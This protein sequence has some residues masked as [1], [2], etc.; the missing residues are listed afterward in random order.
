MLSN[1]LNYQAIFGVVFSR[2]LSSIGTPEKT[3]KQYSADI[4][5]FLIWYE[6]NLPRQP[7]T[8]FDPAEWLRSVTNSTIQSYIGSLRKKNTPASTINRSLAAFRIFFQ[9]AIAYE[10]IREN[11][12]TGIQNV[13]ETS[14][15]RVIDG[16]LTYLNA[17]H[18]SQKT[19]TNYVMDTRHFL[20]W[21]T[22]MRSHDG[23][24]SP[25]ESPFEGISRLTLEHYKETQ[26]GDRVPVAT[27]NR[28]LSALRLFFQYAYEEKLLDT[29]PA[30][31]LQNLL[32]EESEAL[33]ARVSR[34]LSLYKEDTALSPRITSEE[35][36]VIQDF[37]AWVG[38]TKSP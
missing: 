31:S 36:V 12:M 15:E 9:C 27:I 20:S 3:D 19:I 8:L 11:P 21:R 29:N 6:E 33:S 25:N 24:K 7:K 2:Y 13:T 1:V 5:S 35:G 28:R 38:Q 16:Y 32:P 17:R 26:L 18:L 30:V 10:W 23:K 4:R 37:F 34:I 14:A 22:E